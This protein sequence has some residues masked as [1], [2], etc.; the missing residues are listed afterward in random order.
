MND[1]DMP[2]QQ[3]T[4]TIPLL[5]HS[6]AFFLQPNSLSQFSVFFLFSASP[7]LEAPDFRLCLFVFSLIPLVTHSLSLTRQIIRIRALTLS[8]PSDGDRPWWQSV[9]TRK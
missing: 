6:L 9:G 1:G 8:I 7:L 2:I 4:M 5:T 3:L